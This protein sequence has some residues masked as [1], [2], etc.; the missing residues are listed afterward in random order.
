M[1]Y[2]EVK[3]QWNIKDDL[4][5]PAVVERLIEKYKLSRVAASIISE[6]S[7]N[8]FDL[9]ES[10]ILRDSQECRDPMMLNDIDLA[11]SRILKAVENGT[12]TIAIYGDYDVDG[13]TSVSMMYLYLS[14][15]GLRVGYYIPLF[16]Y[17]TILHDKFQ[18]SST[19]ETMA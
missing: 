8:N 14:S 15:L 18:L 17:F 6:R 9:A 11:V 10:Y 19:I 1:Q 7:D 3:K 4:S 12:D 5:S 16:F 2:S 13:V